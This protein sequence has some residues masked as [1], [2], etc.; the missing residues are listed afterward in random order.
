MPTQANPSNDERLDANAPD[1]TTAETKAMES[2]D[3]HGNLKPEGEPAPAIEPAPVAAADP[4]TA[5]APPAAA[6]P[7]APAPV[8]DTAP[9]VPA[10]VAT[11]LQG[12]IF[13]PTI[14]P[15]QARDF[16]GEIK[17]LKT[18]YEAG[19]LDDDQYEAA[20]EAVV[21]ART[22]YNAQSNI[23]E[24]LA[25][26]AWRANVS[27]FLQMPDNATL[28]RSPEM[29]DLW[30]TML[31]RATNV[32]AQEV[33]DGKRAAMPNDWEILTEGRNLLF[34]TLGISSA[35]VPEPP[36]APAKPAAQPKP[37]QSP[38]LKDVPPTLAQAPGAAPTGAK[39]TAESLS[40]AD[41]FEIESLMATQSED[42]ND[43]L[44]RTL[45]GAFAE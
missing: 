22:L 42:Q 20:R 32:A 15:G 44:L 31:Q 10:A 9:A 21:E 36:A 27:A 33:K 3:D 8:A 4:A 45:P 11:P 39:A 28:L 25:D 5:D 38:N 13:T 14:S 1:L 2:F 16:A 7:V 26:S 34:G 18:K 12:P 43:A 23:A 41:I 29:K 40:T 17:D 30:Q 24:Q 6:D 37:N 19:E 35:T